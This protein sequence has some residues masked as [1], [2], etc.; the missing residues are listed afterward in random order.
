M[1]I[2][3]YSITIEF[4]DSF[5]EMSAVNIWNKVNVDTF[6]EGLQSFSDHERAEI[7]AT[8]SDIDNICDH[9][10]SVPS[11]LATVNSVTEGFHLCLGIGKNLASI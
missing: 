8:Y 5:G 3:T 7:G 6:L 2:P 10:T 4:F 11:M 9:F 1:V